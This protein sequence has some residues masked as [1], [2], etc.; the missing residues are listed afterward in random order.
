MAL[1]EA[2]SHGLSC[3][4]SDIPANKEFDLEPDRY[5]A[6]GDDHT[7][8]QK[9]E[10]FSTRPIPENERNAQ[11]KKVTEKYDWNVVAKTTLTVLKRAIA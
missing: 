6:P 2:L 1:L 11:I 9:L 5:F 10:L 7:L 4:A 3:I 8:A